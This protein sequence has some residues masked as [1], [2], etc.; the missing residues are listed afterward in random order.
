MWRTIF[1]VSSS[2]KDLSQTEIEV[3]MNDTKKQNDLNN[4]TGIFMHSDKNFFQIIE[5]K[6]ED[7]EIL[8]KKIKQDPRHFNIIKIFDNYIDN[9]QFST[10]HKSYVTISTQKELKELY[11]FLNKEKFN[12]PNNYDKILYIAQKFL[13]LS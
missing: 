13:K 3:M 7:I 12:Q 6:N 10:F 4:I 5:G 11:K 8:Y 9:P 2:I 1:Y